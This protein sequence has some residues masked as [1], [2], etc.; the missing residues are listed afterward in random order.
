VTEAVLELK[1]P[2]G[3][4]VEEEATELD[5]VT[6][7][8]RE[9]RPLPLPVLDSLGLPVVVRTTD[10]VREGEGDAVTVLTV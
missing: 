10:P 5:L 3:R 7:T 1:E 4:P 8:E 6:E 9:V 2:V